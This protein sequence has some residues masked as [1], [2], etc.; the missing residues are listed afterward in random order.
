MAT[1][2]VKDA[3]GPVLDWLVA[4]CEDESIRVTPTGIRFALSAF[5][6]DYDHYS[7]SGEWTQ[8]G[9]II[10]RELIDIIHARET[11]TAFHGRVSTPPST[12]PTPLIAAMRCYVVSKLGETVEV[13]DLLLKT[14]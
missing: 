5:T 3:V 13:P 9:P 4:Q 2:W 11:W 6:N 14:V 8:G 12:G 7:P 1:I 10:E